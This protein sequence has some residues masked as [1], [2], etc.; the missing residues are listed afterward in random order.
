MRWSRFPL[1]IFAICVACA[2]PVWADDTE[3]AESACRRQ[4]VE[5]QMQTYD[6]IYFVVGQ[7]GGRGFNAKFQISVD[8]QIFCKQGAVSKMPSLRPLR[9]VHFSFSQ[10]SLWDLSELSS[11][12]R[13]SSY[14]PRLF[15]RLRDA[16]ENSSRTLTELDIGIAHESNGKAGVDSRSVDMAFVR[17][18]W[19]F[20][21]GET[22]EREL[23]VQPMIYT[24]TGQSRR[25][26]DIAD[27]RGYVDLHLEYLWGP[28]SADGQRT[29]DPWAF[30]VD[31][32]KGNRSD[33]GTI[34]ASLA[35]PYRSLPIV[36]SF[37]GWLMVQYFNGYGETL[38]DYNRKLDSQLRLGFCIII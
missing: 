28:R 8:F 3:M 38:L 5:D 16:A 17:P 1:W 30:W 33:F 20:G 25:N 21:F 36:E 26:N 7:D 24:Y 19:T 15:Y 37:N 2:T 11:P 12:F 29:R 13:D 10:T 9:Q 32:R 35:V 18:K 14:R 23:N 27:Y 22:R 34:E 4:F 6:P 31:L